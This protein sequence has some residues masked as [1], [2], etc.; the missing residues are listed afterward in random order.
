MQAARAARRRRA[1]VRRKEKYGEQHERPAPRTQGKSRPGRARVGRE[2]GWA[3]AILALAVSSGGPR[4]ASRARRA[5]ATRAHGHRKRTTLAR[6]FSGDD[7]DSARR[8]SEIGATATLW[9]RPPRLFSDTVLEAVSIVMG[10]KRERERE[11]EGEGARERER[12]RERLTRLQ[13]S[14][15]SEGGGG[16]GVNREYNKGGP[17]ALPSTADLAA[18][19]PPCFP[20]HA[21]R[22][23]ACGQNA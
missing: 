3:L 1:A 16:W 23:S 12:E 11:R 22:A 5:R 15:E 20:H 18:I 10:E 8:S 2:V 7:A 9:I 21:H 19:A 13:G 14:R 17:S 6:R 4:D